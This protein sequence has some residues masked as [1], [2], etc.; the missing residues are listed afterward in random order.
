M[1][2]NSDMF[3]NFL[4]GTNNNYGNYYIETYDIEKNVINKEPINEVI[5][6]KGYSKTL[7]DGIKY[8]AFCFDC[9][10]ILIQA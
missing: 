7:N 2:T 4:I 5:S 3:L 9:K 10:K 6:T 8:D 1:S